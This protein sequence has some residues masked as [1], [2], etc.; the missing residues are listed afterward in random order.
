[1]FSG[2]F[3]VPGM[4]KIIQNSRT[5]I[6]DFFLSGREIGFYSSAPAA[7]SRALPDVSRRPRPVLRSCPPAD[8]PTA[9]V[10]GGLSRQSSCRNGSVRTLSYDF[11]LLWQTLYVGYPSDNQ[12]NSA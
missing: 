8:T 7:A 4:Y 6:E 2:L 12:N 5:I 9:R 11:N 1:M 3:A 10:F